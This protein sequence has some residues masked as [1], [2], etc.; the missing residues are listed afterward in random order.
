M[1][2]CAEWRSLPNVVVH[3]TAAIAM[4]GAMMICDC[5]PQERKLMSDWFVL[6][7][8]KDRSCWSWEA[9]ILRGVAI[10]N[11]AIICRLAF[12]NYC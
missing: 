4:A 1:Q 9:R 10:R 2:N 8:A 5:E 6:H 12:L 7:L 3:A 11:S